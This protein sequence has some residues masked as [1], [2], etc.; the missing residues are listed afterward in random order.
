[1]QAL[2]E[3]EELVFWSAITLIC[4]VPVIGHY[5]AKVRRAELDATLKHEMIQRGMSPAEIA[6][7]LQASTPERLSPSPMAMGVRFR[8][9]GHRAS[10]V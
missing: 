6:E 1:M 2:L 4:V 3:N 9:C 10:R 5:W 8:P 7:V